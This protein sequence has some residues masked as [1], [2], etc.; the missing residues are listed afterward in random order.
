MMMLRQFTGILLSLLIPFCSFLTNTN[1]DSVLTESS[2]LAQSFDAGA[3]AVDSGVDPVQADYDWLTADVMKKNNPDLLHITSDLYLPTTGKYGSTISWHLNN[4]T[5]QTIADDG[6][7]T[8]P[9]NA[10]EDGWVSIWA[11]ITYPGK[12]EKEKDFGYV[13]VMK[14]DQVIDEE[15]VDADLSLLEPAPDTYE[16]LSAFQS[17]QISL[18]RSDE[19]VPYTDGGGAELNCGYA[20]TGNDC[21]IRWTS[22][23]TAL[24]DPDNPEPITGPTMYVPV[25]HPTYLEG[26]VTLTLTVTVSRG[27]VSKSKNFQVTVVKQDPEDDDLLQ[28]DANW[29]T[30]SQTLG[31]ENLS[32]Y[33]VTNNLTL[34]TS[35]A[36]NGSAISWS[37]GNPGVI[38]VEQNDGKIVGS[39]TRPD[40]AKGPA[41]VTL[42]ATLT[43]AGCTD[44]KTVTLDYTVLAL[45]D[46]TPPTV[47]SSSPS[48]NAAGVDCSTSRITLTFSEP[49]NRSNSNDAACGIT[50]DQ[51][52]VSGYYA[53]ING[54]TLTVTLP[55]G[56]TCGRRYTMTLPA[57]AVK[58]LAG[59]A[60]EKA[61]S[62]TFQV[63]DRRSQQ[64]L[65]FDTAPYKWENNVSADTKILSVQFAN[66]LSSDPF[67]KGPSFDNV[68]LSSSDGDT[69]SLSKTLTGSTLTLTLSGSSLQ[70]GKIYTL[71]VPAGVVQDK[72]GN[73]SR[74]DSVTF[75]CGHSGAFQI[76]KTYPE[77]GADSV[78]INQ[79]IEIEFSQPITIYG[80]KKAVLKD[81]DGNSVGIETSIAGTFNNMLE[82]HP[83]SALKAKTKY[84]LSI[85]Q[86]YIFSTFGAETLSAS[87]SF[88]TG[89]STL[90]V[91]GTSPASGEN[92]AAVTAC[93]EIDFSGDVACADD[94]KAVTMADAEGNAVAV[95]EEISGS[96]VILTPEQTLSPS[97][98]YT[99]SVPAGLYRLSVSSLPGLVT[100]FLAA[101]TGQEIRNDAFQ[102]NFSTA[103]AVQLSQN[104]D[105]TVNAAQALENKAVQFSCSSIK[106][107]IEAAGRSVSSVHWEFGD[108]SVSSAD[109][110]S[111]TYTAAGD[112]EA[113]LQMTD[114]KGFSYTFKKSMHVQSISYQNVEIDVKPADGNK[115]F[116]ADNSNNV[117]QYYIHPC[118]D[119]IALTNEPVSVKL[120]R[121]NNLVEDCGTV[122]TKSAG[123]YWDPLTGSI[124]S[125]RGMAVF[126]LS[127][128]S[129]FSLSGSYEIRFSCGSGNDTKTVSVPVN[130]EDNI[131]RQ[132]L[133]LKLCDADKN[134]ESIDYRSS[135]TVQL[136]GVQV[137][138]QPKW[139]NSK[140]GYCLEIPNV[141]MGKHRIELC[142]DHTFTLT[143]NND[144]QQIQQNGYSRAVELYVKRRQAG[145]TEVVSGVSTSGT[146]S[147]TPAYFLEGVD[148]PA[149]TFSVLGDWNYQTPGYYEMAGGTLNGQNLRS[150]YT[151]QSDTFSIKPQEL[152]NSG[153]YL[154]CRMVAADGQ[155]SPWVYTNIQAIPAPDLGT[156]TRVWFQDGTYHISAPLSIA[157]VTGG[158]DALDDVP[159]L[160]NATFGL[161]G[162]RYTLTGTMNRRNISLSFQSSASASTENTLAKTKTKTVCAGIDVNTDIEIKYSLEYCG[163][164]ELFAGRYSMS[165]DGTY[166]KSVESAL[167]GLKWPEILKGEVKIGAVVGGTLI[168]EN[169]NTYKGVLE[170]APHVEGDISLDLKAASITGSVTGSIATQMGIDSSGITGISVEPSLKAKIYAKYLWHTQ[171]L[172]KHTFFD[173]TWTWGSVSS[174][175]TLSLKA[176]VSS[177]QLKTADFQPM[178]RSYLSRASVWNGSSQNRLLRMAVSSTQNPSQKSLEENVF[179]DSELSLAQNGGTPWLAWTDD[180]GD[181]SVNNCSQL[182]YSADGG[183][184]C[185]WFDT[186]G[187]GDGSPAVASTGDGVLMAWQN[188]KTPL[189]D[190]TD[191]ST[192]AADSE[193]RVIDEP[194]T[195]SSDGN[196]R[197]LTN[198]NKLDYNPRLA[199]DGDSALLVWQ[200]TA[201]ADPE[202]DSDDPADLYY[203]CWDG[204]LWSD[205]VQIDTDGDSVVDTSLVMHGGED[206]LL[207]T[208]DTDGDLS[209]TDD[210]ELFA[211]EYRDGSWGEA[212]QITDNEVED[213]APQA[214]FVDGDWFLLWNE[215]GTV[216]YKTGLNGEMK[217]DDHLS[218]VGS[219]YELTANSAGSPDLALVYT[220]AGDN[221]TRT[222]S[223][224]FYD[225]ENGVWSAEVPLTQGDSGYVKTFSPSFTA[226]GKLMVAYTRA[227]MVNEVVDGVTYPGPSSKADLK[228][229][230][231]TPVHALSLDSD[232]GLTFSTDNPLPDVSETVTAT[233][234]NEGDCAENATVTLYRGDPDKGGVKVGEATTGQPVAGHTSEEVQISWTPGSDLDGGCT[235]YAAVTDSD[236][237][238]EG[239]SIHQAVFSSNLTLSDV[240][241]INPGGNS[242]LLTATVLNQGG[243]TLSGASVKLTDDKSGKLLGSATYP[244]LFS[245]QS[246]AVN[247]TFSSDGLTKDA[248][249]EIG[250][251]LTAVLPTGLT[252]NTPDDNVYQFNLEPAS[253]T[254]KSITP[255]PGDTQVALQAPI[256][257]VFNLDIGKGSD[258]DG[259]TLKDENLNPV[260]ITKT[261]SGST[262]TVTPTGTMKKGT[263][264]LLTI[265]KD[266]LGDSYGHTMEEPYSLSFTTITSSPA[267]VF[268]NPGA[269]MANVSTSS[270]ISLKYNQNVQEGSRM[271]EITITGSDASTVSASTAIN[272]QWLVL[273]PS[274]PLSK[275]VRYFVSV[276]SGTVENADGEIQREAYSI[277]F[278]TQ[279]SLSDLQSLYDTCSA[280][281][282]NGYTDAS[283]AAFTAALEQT[284]T[285]LDDDSPSENEILAAITALTS[286]KNELTAGHKDTDGSTSSSSETTSSQ[287]GQNSH[288][289]SD[290][291]GIYHFSS[292]V[293]YYYKITTPDTVVPTAVSSNPQ[294]A[295]VELAKKLPDGYLFRITNVGIG[296]ATITT[297]AGDGTTTSFL[298]Q[299]TSPPQG[300]AS[301]TPYAHTMKKGGTYQFKFT[302]VA[303]DG[304]PAFS[305]GGSILRPVSLRR[306]GNVYYYKILMTGGGS[307]GVYVTLPHR[308]PVRR[309]VVT[310]S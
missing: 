182:R 231:Y 212:Q 39:V 252:D 3:A 216:V 75:L 147:P 198:D 68:S 296:Q 52:D 45:D 108:G 37:S 240:S 12:G 14:S 47:A 267:V 116:N 202:Q 156:G 50:F 28:E 242:Y 7:I 48:N 295:T 263:K 69:L 162:G 71:R 79:N 249:G 130:I 285:V 76:S 24:I 58:D 181:G 241:C 38:A 78:G 280:I 260:E 60:L 227:D 95:S 196:P 243:Q 30:A 209:T 35:A 305:V 218:A 306:V 61:Y 251:T 175:S 134:F 146:Y 25:N 192:V 273:K 125:Y 20:N 164:W 44:P 207:Y 254:V 128:S 246:G 89:G 288:F 309:C 232:A 88:T 107:K 138:A 144:S 247:I 136:D 62:L 135:L 66:I 149:V 261:V 169:L 307:A 237:R 191:V 178:D 176:F 81:A 205:P 262:L 185:S 298:V 22:S 19:S 300:I 256:S 100:A 110:P 201:A 187:T 111:H 230:T 59:N 32:Q 2:R 13:H 123:E 255:G 206:L 184:T 265:P 6:T 106:N 211:V 103:G 26:N 229:L 15:R 127:L 159:L 194:L 287:P 109:S 124:H 77:N 222:L 167:P 74:A 53:S 119:N 213:S 250:L 65:V 73:E 122:T 274:K 163:G 297:A 154:F 99:V 11:T 294:V 57:G 1:M 173:Q 180:N 115:N 234:K 208:A 153:E 143:G 131:D 34:P 16:D 269:N 189:S 188:I 141:A 290:T 277:S 9:D 114:S 117:K 56:L 264:Y 291:T 86:D 104:A 42:T 302:A 292:N 310:G 96:K 244:Q 31:A 245:G 186:D 97:E 271:S 174:L 46:T 177:L 23:N 112:F 224:S 301:D 133:R 238:A 126:A 118:Y 33:A 299:Q 161:G 221:G 140:D 193:I 43:R 150:V 67:S 82:V 36:P 304:I 49:V 51:T 214:A 190:G 219:R 40:T 92:S 253:L 83:V 70:A 308:P 113:Q 93:P 84:T 85:P 132:T 197:N 199:A 4:G 220:R 170:F 105:M 165:G 204:N 286:A 225:A 303:A 148:R 282:R 171:T 183:S 98:T 18:S 158:K 5:D 293:V 215:N 203:S 289:R 281:T 152:L 80:W 101:V 257:A 284:Q 233:V 142:Y 168:I 129:T 121:D 120:Y 278:Q 236:G 268:S 248:D 8:R 54:K 10:L 228:L 91:T 41:A 72:Y 151:S 258:F 145:I 283:W 239:T 235:L 17:S 155:A 64:I 157:S 21:T 259:I 210:R 223:A 272:G 27:D 29:L 160:Q 139:Y 279:S 217:Q 200:K 90:A 137:T 172:Y 276:P 226:D 275:G 195:G 102:F 94:S 270:G 63:E 166:H 266:A 55:D 87:V 179:P